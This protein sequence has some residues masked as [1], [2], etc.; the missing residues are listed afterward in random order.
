MRFIEYK[1]STVRYVEEKDKIYHG[2]AL[3]S[4]TANLLEKLKYFKNES[5]LILVEIGDVIFR[6]FAL[7][8]RLGIELD[9]DP[10]D[11]EEMK[12]QTDTLDQKFKI[13]EEDLFQSIILELGIISNIMT[14]N[15]RYD[16]VEFTASDVNRLKR[17]IYSYVMYLLI[18]SCKYNFSID[19]VLDFSVGKLKVKA[20]ELNVKMIE[21]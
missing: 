17:S 19:R 9:A 20:K 3:V 21:E 6:L 12:E 2:F 8:D 15:M 5:S 4:D 13:S 7:M 16:V 18:L 11:L 14:T 1:A 10:L